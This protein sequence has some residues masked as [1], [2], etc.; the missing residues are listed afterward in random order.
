MDTCLQDCEEKWEI[1]DKKKL[2][3]TA[4]VSFEHKEQVRAISKFKRKE[5][6]LKIRK[7]NDEIITLFLFITN[8]IIHFLFH[9]ESLKI[10]CVNF[11][12]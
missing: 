6:E 8:Y 11:F 12:T 2:K 5:N 9:N 1:I 7:N 10:I 4:N 3:L